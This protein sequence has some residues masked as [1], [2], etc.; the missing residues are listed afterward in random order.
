MISGPEM[1][2]AI[3]V[4]GATT[5]TVLGL[6][7]MWMG[8]LEARDRARM[9]MSPSGVEDRLARIEHAV[10]AIAIEME[11]VSEGQRFTTKLLSDRHG[12]PPHS[13]E[14]PPGERRS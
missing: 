4:V 5:G 2:L 7:K 6:T 1:V 9:T 10:D 3:V 13:P 11:R 12:Q 8:R 14:S